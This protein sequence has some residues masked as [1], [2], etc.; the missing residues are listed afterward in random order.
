MKGGATVEE[1]E[2]L[3]RGS[4]WLDLSSRSRLCLLGRDRV[5]F[6]N[7]QVTCDLGVLEPGQGRYTLVTDSRGRV[8]GDATVYL[9]EEE[10][11]LDCEPGCAGALR[12]RFERFLV[13]DDVEIAD[14]GPL[15]GLISVQGPDSVRALE[16]LGLGGEL[17]GPGRMAARDHPLWGEVHLARR[18][19]FTPLGYDLY[20]P[21]QAAPGLRRALEEA[22][23]EPCGTDS[24]EVLRLEAG[25]PR[26]PVDMAPGILAPELGPEEGVVGYSKGCYI[27]QEVLNR[28]RAVGRL[29]RRL[30]RVEIGEGEA[31]RGRTDLL[32]GG[33]KAGFLS[34]HAEDPRSGRRLGLAM[35]RREHAREGV[36]LRC[37]G[38]GAS[39]SATVLA[40]AG[41]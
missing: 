37:S 10:L 1:L 33:R 38:E 8:E 30:V 18:P 3:Q 9:L 16:A 25:V 23:V 22:G 6:L 15:V 26:F 34:S 5:R 29:N 24:L 35:V 41:S 27:G 40:L 17:P 12:Q 14:A 28:I 11:L 21:P 7:G 20:H 36:R 13:A 19:R 39:A 31:G 4:A 32:A 2:R